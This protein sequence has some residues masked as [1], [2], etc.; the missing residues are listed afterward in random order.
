MTENM[1]ALKEKTLISLKLTKVEKKIIQDKA[2]A[3]GMNFSSYVRHILCYS[4]PKLKT[5]D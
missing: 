3:V 2:D 5:N 1:K 4:T